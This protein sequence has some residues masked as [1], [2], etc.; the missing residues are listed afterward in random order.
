MIHILFQSPLTGISNL[1][2]AGRG[3][4]GRMYYLLWCQYEIVG[5]S[6]WGPQRQRVS[7]RG[8]DIETYKEFTGPKVFL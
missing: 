4:G 6:V 7:L 8:L 2:V 3:W 5:L 1:A